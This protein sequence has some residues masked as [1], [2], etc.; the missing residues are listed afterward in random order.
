MEGKRGVNPAGKD[1]LMLSM[2]RKPH[3]SENDRCGFSMSCISKNVELFV[4]FDI[5]QI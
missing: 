3:R 1:I 5:I 2:D 4:L